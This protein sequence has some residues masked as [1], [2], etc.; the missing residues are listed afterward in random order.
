MSKEVHEFAESYMIKLLNLC[1][2]Y[3]QA[4]AYVGSSNRTL[5]I[6]IKN[7]IA[8]HPRNLHKVL[9]EA[10]WSNRISK[11]CATKVSPFEIL[12]MGKKLFC[13]WR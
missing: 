11:H 12:F 6:L 9:S 13:L 5:I 8:N 3:S 2:Y 1:P 7:K 4:N 10:L